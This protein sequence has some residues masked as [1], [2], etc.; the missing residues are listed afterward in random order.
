[1]N[2]SIETEAQNEYELDVTPGD[3]AYDFSKDPEMHG[4]HHLVC[5]KDR[6]RYEND[7]E[8][9][10][11]EVGRLL[12]RIENLEHAVKKLN[13]LFNWD[14]IWELVQEDLN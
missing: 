3:L 10:Q 14:E 13:A 4:H 11:E 12:K 7:I 5:L 1:M 2:E 6:E 9:L 8:E